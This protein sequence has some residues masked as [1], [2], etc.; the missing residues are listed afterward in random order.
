MLVEPG[1]KIVGFNEFILYIRI[2]KTIPEFARVSVEHNIVSFQ[3]PGQPGGDAHAVGKN[4]A[5]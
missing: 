5:A 2:A 1:V 3:T 4:I